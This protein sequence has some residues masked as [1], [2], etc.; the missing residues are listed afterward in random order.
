MSKEKFKSLRDL[1]EFEIK[2]LYSAE[3]QLEKALPKMAETASDKELKDSFK[4]HLEETKEQRE[5]LEKI[6][7]ICDFS[8][9]GHTCDAMKGLIKEGEEVIESEADAPIKDA[10]LISASQRVEH[11]EIA[12]YGTVRNFAKKLGFDE[13]AD[14]LQ[15]TLDQEK[16]TDMKLN[17]LAVDKINDKAV[18]AS[19]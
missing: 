7:E 12:A 18:K 10:A 5:R 9:K 11:Y 3:T 13:V 16:E 15:M 14:L 2:D 8:V 1:F 4:K 6:G 17:K 19:K